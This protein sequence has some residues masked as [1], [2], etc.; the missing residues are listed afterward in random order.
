M[1]GLYH[2]PGKRRNDRL[3]IG[4]H[5]HGS[6]EMSSSCATVRAR[7]K[8]S[9]SV[10]EVK[11]QYRKSR[12]C[13]P[14]CCHAAQQHAGSQK[15]FR[16]SRLCRER[17]CDTRYGAANRQRNISRWYF[18]SEPGCHP[19]FFAANNGVPPVNIYLTALA[20]PL[21]SERALTIRYVAAFVGSLTIVAVY[22]LARRLMV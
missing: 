1:H 9:E 8:R 12:Y 15:K 11:S 19:I 22:L 2:A 17:G 21:S 14:E 4:S 5:L 10:R 18:M 7:L 3:A 20:F 6:A 13:H 16:L